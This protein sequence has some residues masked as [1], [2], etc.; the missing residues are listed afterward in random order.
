MA[1]VCQSPAGSQGFT[2]HLPVLFLGVWLSVPKASYDTAQWCHSESS[3]E[4]RAVRGLLVVLHSLHC[5]G[6]AGF[7]P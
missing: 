1:E 3:C 5:E 4:E 6:H 7:G 2:D